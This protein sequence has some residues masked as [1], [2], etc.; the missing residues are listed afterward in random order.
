MY[1]LVK[2]WYYTF[3]VLE[4]IHRQTFKLSTLSKRNLLT[5]MFL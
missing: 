4:K 1:I 2:F 3:K 5:E